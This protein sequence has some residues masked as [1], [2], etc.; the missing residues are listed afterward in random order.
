M[1]KEIKKFEFVQGVNFEVIDSI[2]NNGTKY[3]L[4]IDDSCEEICNSK[5][6][7]TLPPLGDIGV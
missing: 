5:T 4:K 6:L 3:L 2:K 7:L 1:Q